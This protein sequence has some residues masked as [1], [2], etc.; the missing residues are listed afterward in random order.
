MPGSNGTF[1]PAITK[2][3]GR[4]AATVLEQL[5]LK[6]SGFQDPDS[7]WNSQ[8]QRYASPDTL[9]MIAASLFFQDASITLTYDNGQEKTEDSFA[10][11]RPTV[12]FAAIKSGED[13]YNEFCTPDPLALV[14]DPAATTTEPGPTASPTSTSGPAVAPTISGYP[15]PVIRDNGGNVT[16]GYFLNGTGYE[17]VA[18]LSV[19][20]FAPEGTLDAETYLRNFQ[21]TVEKFLA[22]CKSENKK[23]LVIDVSGNG[24]GFVISGYELFA[25][26]RDQQGL[27]RSRKNKD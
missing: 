20:S 23:R 22:Q 3:N 2:I 6:Y 13:F 21:E 8:F 19:T 5:N 24:G 1:P 18:V 11:V 26:V 14:A 25:Q 9:P 27:N 12:D 10:A 16:S 15:F 7:Q 17:D 4:D